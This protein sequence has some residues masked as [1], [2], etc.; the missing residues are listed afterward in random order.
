VT[1]VL[2]RRLIVAVGPGGVG[3]TSASAAMAVAA[4]ARGRRVALLTIDPARRLADALGLHG[5]DDGMR[6]V[7]LDALVDQPSGHLHA[8]M[9]DTK[10][11]FDNLITRLAD[12]PAPIL[13]NRVYQAFSRTLAR[14]HAYVAMERLYDLLHDDAYDLVVLDTPPMRSAL[15][16]LDAPAQLRAFLDETIIAAFFGPGIVGRSAR[17]TSAIAGRLLSLVAGRKL[18]GE[19]LAFFEAFMPLREGFAARATT[20]EQA[21]QSESTAFVL[22]TAPEAAHLGDAAYLR[23]GLYTREL[24]P[25]LVVFNRA[26]LPDA[27]GQPVTPAAGPDER[28]EM[29]DQLDPTPGPERFA[30]RRTLDAIAAVRNELATTNGRALDAMQAFAREGE[31]AVQLPH[32]DREPLSP[33]ALLGLWQQARPLG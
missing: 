32:L 1:D 3:K 8:A 28:M 11:S 31:P 19:M 30:L 17:G 12:D 18:V 23:D 25:A 4:A 2:E 14:S 33:A 7:P 24:K 10:R 26:F 15:D 16:I 9:L 29:L 5:L 27:E 22:V 13:D 21:L 20:T 6:P